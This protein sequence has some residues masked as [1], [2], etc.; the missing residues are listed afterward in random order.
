MAVFGVT[1]VISSGSVSVSDSVSSRITNG[2]S[3]DRRNSGVT[4]TRTSLSDRTSAGTSICTGSIF[5][6][7]RPSIITAIVLTMTLVMMVRWSKAH[8]F[9]P[10]VQV[11]RGQY[12]STSST[13]A[14]AAASATSTST[15]TATTTST[16]VNPKGRLLVLGG[17]GYLGQVVCA[18]AVQ[19]GYS[20]VTV[21]RRGA[22]AATST[23]SFVNSNSRIDY[24]KGDARQKESITNILQ[25]G[26][27]CGIIHCIGLL[28]DTASGFG[29]YNI[30]VSGSQSLPDEDSTYDTITR[31]TA[32]HA[33]DAAMEYMQQ[34]QQQL[35]Q[36]QEGEQQQLDDSSPTTTKTTITPLP[37]C[38]TSAAEAG[39]PQMTGGPQIERIMPEFIQRY[40]LAKRAVE[41]KLLT[42]PTHQIRPIIV[43]PSLIYSK[44][45]FAS[46][47][48]VAA[49]TILN[50]IGLPFVDR[51]VTVDALATVM[52]KSMQDTNIRGIQRY[53]QI[54]ALS[55]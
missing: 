8:A 24:R 47:P 52:I 51:P 36:Q 15:S 38:F 1:S 50:K 33:I 17:T 53:P 7:T 54:D 6:T 3:D 32:F 35:Q 39:W 42:T 23:S 34:Q 22:P 37:F 40:M 10:A 9:V 19:E 49:F 46:L 29:S 20:V 41:T 27:I 18:K 25:E 14:A 5:T 21:S 31:Q 2:D 28:F 26:N 16:K 44:D 11:Q 13:T 12:R 43:R 55:Q 48:S 4:S 30:Y 45:K